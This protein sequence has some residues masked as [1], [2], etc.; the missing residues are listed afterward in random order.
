MN[1]FK[2][3]L[4]KIPLKFIVTNLFFIISLIILYL[5]SGISL[6]TLGFLFDM[7]F[8]VGLVSLFYF[9]IGNNLAKNII[10]TFI[11]SIFTFL[12][13]VDHIYHGMFSKFASAS[14]LNN[15]G[16]VLDNL[17]AYEINIDIINIL[18]LLVLGLFI[19]FLFIYKD[20]NKRFK[21]RVYYSIP[22]LLILVPFITIYILC[23]ND[24]LLLDLLLFPKRHKFPNFI[25]NF[26]YIFYRYEDIMV[27]LEGLGG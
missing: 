11:G 4:R 7:C 5:S 15:A 1:K 22:T 27:V 2:N 18:L 9:A 10:F 24:Q 13:N 20:N 3:F 12:Y 19:T 25:N 6:F 17:G 16:M 14:S 26:G 21:E 23:Y 8:F